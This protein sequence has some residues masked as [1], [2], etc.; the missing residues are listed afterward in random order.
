MLPTPRNYAAYP[1]VMLADTP[2]QMTIA[3][4]EKAFLFFEGECY[5]LTIIDINSDELY[6]HAPVSHK[7]LSVTAHGGV[8]SFTYT[9]EGEQEHL[10][11]IEKDGKKLQEI[12]VYSLHKD[13]YKLTPLKGDFHTHSYRSDGKRDPAAHAGHFREQGYDFFALTDHNRYY[14]GSEIDETYEDVK[15]AFTRVVGEE[16][17]APGSVIHIVHVGGS[18]SVAA[19]YVHDREGYEAECQ[20]LMSVVPD[21]VPGKYRERYARSLWVTKKIHDVGGLAIFPHPYWQPGKARTYNVCDEF[22]KILL[23]SGMFDAYE[24]I[25]GMT[26]VGCN[27][28]VALWSELR[29]E[30]LKISVVGS[31][32]VHGI[33]NSP[34]F[35]HNFTIC[36][37]ESNTNDDII[38]AVKQGMSVAVESCGVEATRQHRC[39]GSL[40]LVSYAQFLLTHF[41]PEMTRICQ[42]EGVA[43]RSYAMGTADAALIEAQ[44]R[45]SE[46]YRAR[47]FGRVTP[48]L[49]S[50]DIIA[51][52]DKWRKVHLAGPH[53]KG[54]L[55]D[56]KTVSRQI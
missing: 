3:P 53:T 28:S 40:R 13:L 35:P 54:S 50:S 43:M 14:P 1:A 36:F 8:L 37:A 7:K 29:G 39:Y 38:A 2:V 49:P 30:G 34:F 46:A 18:E 41:F 12:S 4:T 23:N 52:E 20:S 5:D 15:L 45:H 11:I 24:L 21:S 32:D 42:G 31:S 10:I 55:V 25:G 16:V 47:F 6:Y 56:S 22:A 19:R 17:H 48:T 44:A 26:P 33:E 51:F 9:F 27:R